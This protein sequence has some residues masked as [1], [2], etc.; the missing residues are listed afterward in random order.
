MKISESRRLRGEKKSKARQ[1]HH[2]DQVSGSE[3]KYREMASLL[4]LGGEAATKLDITRIDKLLKATGH[5]TEE[6]QTLV[7]EF[8]V[9]QREQK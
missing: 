2:K 9:A 8:R 3:G 4:A 6:L 5:T 1:Q 7:N